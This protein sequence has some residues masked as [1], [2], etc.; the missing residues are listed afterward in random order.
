VLFIYFYPCNQRFSKLF[1]SKKYWKNK[2]NAVMF[3]LSSESPWDEYSL[4]L[5]PIVF[6]TSALPYS[7]HFFLY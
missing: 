4:P 3:C 5:Q 6:F 7:Q 1:N 2:A